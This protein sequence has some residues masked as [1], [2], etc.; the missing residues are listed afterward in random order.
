MR[1]VQEHLAAVLTLAGPVDPLDVVLRDAAGCVLAADVVAPVDVPPTTV[2]DCDG[3]AVLAADT[4]DRSPLP[5]AHDAR[6]G[7][8]PPLLVPGQAVRVSS[9]VPLPA[10]ADAVV[11]LD[12]TDRDAVAVVVRKMTVVEVGE[13]RGQEV[14]PIAPILD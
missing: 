14:Q 12:D 11:R 2:A 9:G 3:Y 10:G 6:P 8:D 13:R 1:S 7:A 4:Q 5:V